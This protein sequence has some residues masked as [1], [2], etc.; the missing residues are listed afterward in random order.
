MRISRVTVENFRSYKK[1]DLELPAG[2][3]LL[4]GDVGSGKSTILYAIEFALFGLGGL[5][6]SHLLRHGAEE[7]SVEVALEVKGS[8]VRVKR[9]IKKKSGRVAQTKGSIEVDGVETDYSPSEM[10]PAILKILGFNEPE[11]ARNTSVIYRYAVFTPQ[12]EMKAVLNEKPDE[13]LQTLRKVFGVE[14][15][16]S[17]RDNAKTY[18][19]QIKK[20]CEYLRG[21][22][23]GLEEDEKVVEE[24]GEEKK[25]LQKIVESAEQKKRSLSDSLEKAREKEAAL[26]EKKSEAA[27][28]RE[29]VNSL[30]TLV[31]RI[32]S[33]LESVKKERGELQIEKPEEPKKPAETPEEL[34]KKWL[35]ARELAT[36]TKRKEAVLRAESK[37]K[38]D[39]AKQG[40]CPTCGQKISGEMVGDA[41]SEAK[42][43][44]QLLKESVEAEARAAELEK[45]LDEAR[46]LAQARKEF[47]LRLEAAKKAEKRAVE[48]KKRVEREEKELE[49][50][51][52]ELKQKKKE[53]KELSSSLKEWEQAKKELRES[54]EAFSRL[55]KA[56]E[57]AKAKLEE[58]DS[59]LNEKRKRLE[60]ARSE[61]KRLTELLERVE[62]LDQKF[63]PTVENVEE[64]VLGVINR[65]FDSQFR[66]WVFALLE[67][68]ELD[69]RVDASFAPQI[70]QDGYEQDV[71]ALSGGEKTAVAL[72]YRLALNELTRREYPALK[73]NLLILDE[74]TDGFSKE[75]LYKMRAVFDSI[76]GQVIVVSHERELE[77]FADKVFR[78]VK[79]GDSEI[80]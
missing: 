79:D 69:A 23:R 28:A 19:S 8:R 52:R 53:I 33:S 13:R 2:S 63:V 72:A 36:E 49:E 54:E 68:S 6:A 39:L 14:E 67:G 64:E 74:P 21:S 38:K 15:Y 51:R 42:K 47:E 58:K 57:R 46:R 60:K 30:S 55:E 10:K 32:E 71:N 48:L 44:E 26:Q 5:K 35:K 25:E 12:E 4:E 31:Q 45:R 17:A 70:T 37:R 41:E 80:V 77:A 73:E 1:A 56:L 22:T 65:E 18:S 20:K 7:A 78:V 76:N 9:G 59:L 50:K 24:L 34:H 66:K 3:V 29:S 27:A 61:K 11:G 16:K 43:A 40:R 75:Q 62:W